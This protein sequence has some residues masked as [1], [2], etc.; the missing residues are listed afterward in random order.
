MVIYEPQDE[1]Q[2]LSSQWFLYICT[3]LRSS[4][5]ALPRVWLITLWQFVRLNLLKVLKKGISERVC[6]FFFG[7]YLI[8]W[9]CWRQLT[10][11]AVQRDHWADWICQLRSPEPSP[12]VPGKSNQLGVYFLTYLRCF[13]TPQKSFSHPMPRGAF[14]CWH[15]SQLSV[16]RKL[17]TGRAR[18]SRFRDISAFWAQLHELHG[19]SQARTNRK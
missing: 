15:L 5:V 13:H 3:T 10:W 18:R 9:T 1:L 11:G 2:I 14:A 16:T 4:D 19:L 12:A 7:L 6:F 8:T 17:N